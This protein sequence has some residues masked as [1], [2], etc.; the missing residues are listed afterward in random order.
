M[1]KEM[2]DVA[3]VLFSKV[4]EAP[5]LLD[6]RLSL[7]NYE[8]TFMDTCNRHGSLGVKAY[9]TNSWHRHFGVYIPDYTGFSWLDIQICDIDLS[10]VNHT[11]SLRYSE[12]DKIERF[13]MKYKKAKFDGCR[14]EEYYIRLG[15]VEYLK[16]VMQEV[17]AENYKNGGRI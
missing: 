2:Y 11:E 13:L 4:V 1:N 14:S 9:R 12:S 10:G 6:T 7:Y 16:E 17:M 3:I 5:I 15:D 8:T